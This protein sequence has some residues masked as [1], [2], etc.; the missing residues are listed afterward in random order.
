[1]PIAGNILETRI[2]L[3]NAKFNPTQKIITDPVKTILDRTA[4]DADALNHIPNSV[5][6]PCMIPIGIAAN[7]QPFPL[8]IVIT[9][10]VKKSITVLVISRELSP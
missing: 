9:M 8:G 7:K 5:I 6:S 4:A 2:F 3:S 10:I 1:M